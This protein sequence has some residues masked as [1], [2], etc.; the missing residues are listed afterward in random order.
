[1]LFLSPRFVGDPEALGIFS[2]RG[3][4]NLKE[5]THLK[6]VKVRRV[7]IDILVEGYVDT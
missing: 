3:V 7:D 5:A 4:E 2:G 1:M 6:E